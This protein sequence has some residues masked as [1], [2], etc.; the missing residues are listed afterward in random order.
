VKRALLHSGL[1]A[2]AML[3]SAAAHADGL[4]PLNPEIAAHPYRLAPGV[5]EYEHRLSVSPAFGTFGSDRMFAFRVT[6]NPTDWLGYEASLAHTPGQSVHAVLH[7]VNAVV[8]HPFT[9]RFQPYL[10]AGYGM[11][12]VYPGQAVNALPVTKNTLAAG[13]GLEMYIRSDLALRGDL[14]HATVFGGQRDQDGIV[15][16]PYTQATVGLA[17]YRTVRP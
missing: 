7:T 13:G 11:I 1:L 15:A 16:Y 4:E 10:T 3:V 9:G 2:A 17:F 5:R 12:I 14:R 6:Y 8:R